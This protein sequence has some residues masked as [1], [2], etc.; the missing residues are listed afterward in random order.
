MNGILV[1]NKFPAYPTS[2]RIAIIGEFPSNDDTTFGQPFMGTSGRFLSALLSRA[3]ISRDGCF[4]G[5]ISQYQVAGA[6]LSMTSTEAADGMYQLGQ[7]LKAFKPNLV[8]LLGNASLHA[9]KAYGT[10]MGKRPE[11]PVSK[12]RGSLF[13][14]PMDGG[15]FAGYKCM[16]TYLPAYCLRDY[17]SVPLLQF[18]LKKAFREG[19]TP[20]LNLP[21]RNITI[22]YDETKII[23]ALQTLRHNQRAVALDIEGGIDCMSCVSFADTPETAFIVPIFNK[24]GDWLITA[25]TWREL[26]LTLEDPNVPKVLQNSLYDRFVL[27]YSYGIRVQGVL[28]DT[29]LKH[30]ELYSELEKNLGVQTSIYTDEPFY[31]GDRKSDDDR[32]FYEYCCRDSAVTLEISNKLD[33]YFTGTAYPITSLTWVCSTPSYTWNCEGY[34]IM[35][36]VQQK[37][38]SFYV[39]SYM[40]PKPVLTD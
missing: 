39:E 28:H 14:A 23:A 12:W 35:F 30:W 21:N 40:K 25:Q 10:E 1:P 8:V 19:K 27:H 5:N 24:A 18:D 32:T 34:G 3:G 36:L 33:R 7:D 20:L 15:P 31:K 26:A 11:Y 37:D 6:V 29:M 38:G 22:E 16:A 2:Y 4:L 17:E 9:A 13:L